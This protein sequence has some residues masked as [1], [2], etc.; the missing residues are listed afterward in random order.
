MFR[1]QKIADEGPSDPFYA[2]LWIGILDLKNMALRCQS[3]SNDVEEARVKFDDSYD[4]VLKALG[5]AR[6]AMKNTQHVVDD[7]VRKLATSEI[8]EF[9]SS[10]YEISESIDKPLRDETTAFLVHGVIAMKCSQRLVEQFGINIG[11]LFTKQANFEKG[12]D[13]LTASGHSSLAQFLRDVRSTWSESFIDR[14]NALE[15]E[16]WNLPPIEYK[17]SAPKKVELIEPEIGGVALRRY[18]TET[19]NRISSFVENVVVYAFKQAFGLPIALVEIPK[20]RRNPVCPTRFRLD[21]KRPGVEE[22]NIHYS[23]GDFP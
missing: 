19:L 18:S 22:W 17:I 8:V 21:L 12:A 5:A 20:E 4:S 1:I 13:Q 9:Q 10:A 3:R 15:H 7:H 2:R 16:A 23:E 14:R 6:T 11:C